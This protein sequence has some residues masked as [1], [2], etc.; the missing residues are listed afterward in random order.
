MYE[1][2]RNSYGESFGSDVTECVLTALGKF[3][4]C[5][6]ERPCIDLDNAIKYVAWK[7]RNTY[8]LLVKLRFPLHSHS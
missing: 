4:R 3:T 8:A 7:H 1:G 2:F 5:D 6:T